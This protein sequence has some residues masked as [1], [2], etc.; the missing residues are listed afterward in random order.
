LVRYKTPW[1]ALNIVLPFVIMAGYGL[2]QLYKSDAV[3]RWT[4]VLATLVAIAISS[5]Q[6]FTLSFEDYD[7]D[8]KAYVYAHTRRDFLSLVDEIYD[9]AAGSPA[10]NNIGIIVMSPEHWPLPWYLRNYPRTLYSGK[11]IETSEPI[12]VVHESQ[13]SEVE[14]LYGG[15]YRRYS[16]HELRPGNILYLYVKN[17]G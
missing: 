6:A 12:L 8:S 14:Q 2:E 15:R 16:R 9:I 4:A 17:G 13:L 10:G 5:Y 7:D 11:V 1:C 3:G